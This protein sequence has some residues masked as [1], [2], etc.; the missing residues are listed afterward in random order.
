MLQQLMVVFCWFGL[1]QQRLP[2]CWSFV[3][4]GLA[5]FCCVPDVEW[6]MSRFSSSSDTCGYMLIHLL[7]EESL[8]SCI[9][10][11][12]RELQW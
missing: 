11:A 3:G 6:T 10:H 8:L 9:M 1:L 12:L 4:S 7:S 5:S 2:L